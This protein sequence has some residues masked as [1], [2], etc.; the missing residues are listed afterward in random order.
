MHSCPPHGSHVQDVE[1]IEHLAATIITGAA[2]EVDIVAT[3]D[4]A[5]IIAFG[6]YF[7]L[8]ARPLP[9]VVSNAVVL[10]TLGRILQ[11]DF[12]IFMVKH[13]LTPAKDVNISIVHP[14]RGP[15]SDF[16][17][18]TLGAILK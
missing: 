2:K 9:G 6:W 17:R 3:Y 7:S 13:Y 8:L 5:R 11:I 1:V 15:I 14:R 4:S 16:A 10:E 12:L 18:G